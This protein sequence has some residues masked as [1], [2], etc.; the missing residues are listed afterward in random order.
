MKCPICKNNNKLQTRIHRKNVFK[1]IPYSKAYKCYNCES[2][3]ISILKI[4]I[5]YKIIRHLLA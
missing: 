1:L 2:E 5:P 3:Y 4:A